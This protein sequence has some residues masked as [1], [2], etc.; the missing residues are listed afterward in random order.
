M[1]LPT[2][3]NRSDADAVIEAT[4]SA[5]DPARL[6]P[7]VTYSV[8]VPDGSV[9]AIIDTDLLLDIPKRTKGNVYLHEGNALAA[10][11]NRFFATGI[12]ADAP[13]ATITAVCNGP[14]ED[15]PG[16]GDHRAVLALQHTP[17]WKLWSCKSGTLGDQ[18]RLAELFEDRIMD[19]VDPDG[20]TMLEL[21]Q[22]FHA[23]SSARFKSGVRLASG[24]R[25]FVYEETVEARAGRKGDLTV[26]E[27]FTLSLAP[28]VGEEPVT[29]TARLRFRV[30]G[31]DLQIGFVIDRLADVL[32][33]A[34]TN[35]VER[36]EGELT[37]GTPVYFGAAPE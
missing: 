10:Y 25:Q 9:Q 1:T 17:E 3:E 26:P 12:F 18:V 6:E 28:F 31:G 29:L 24:E 30:N 23:S 35:A 2:N 19:I 14:T 20:A 7:G 37:T 34:F 13:K 15:G 4:M 21:A 33:D 11:V 16:W 36:I 27:R 32:R 5:V 8:I 22:S